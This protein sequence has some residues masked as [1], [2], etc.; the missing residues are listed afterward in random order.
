M[1]WFH[2]INRWGKV[3]FFHAQSSCSICLEYK[4]VLIINIVLNNHGFLVVQIYAEYIR[5]GGQADQGGLSCPPPG[6]LEIFD[7]LQIF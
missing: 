3:T 2:M 1:Y 6:M 5:G 4:V 7:I